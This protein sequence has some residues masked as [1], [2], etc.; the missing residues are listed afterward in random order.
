MIAALVAVGGALL[1]ALSYAVGKSI[2]ETEK[3]LSEKRRVYEEFLRTCPLPNDSYLPE[4]E[5]TTAS[6]DRFYRL[7]PTVLFYA[8][9]NVVRAINKYLLD[10]SAA[11]D[12][13][14]GEPMEQQEPFMILAKAH[15][16]IIL[17]MR[18]DAL[19]WSAFGYRGPSRIPK[20]L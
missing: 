10:F 11:K 2:N 16:D 5:Q 7:L 4:T 1:S 9:E 14:M 13:L 3:A 20:S 17:E 12:L 6:L 8:S 18:R 15:N 19:S